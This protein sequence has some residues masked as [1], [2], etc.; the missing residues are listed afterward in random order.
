MGSEAAVGVGRPIVWAL[1]VAV[2]MLV[3]TPST[4]AQSPLQIV[5]DAPETCEAEVFFRGPLPDPLVV[6]WQVSGGEPPYEVLIDGKL[7]EGAT[8][9]VERACGSSIPGARTSGPITIQAAVTDG[10]GRRASALADIYALRVF[11]RSA[12]QENVM[13]ANETYRVHQLLLTIPPGEEGREVRVGGLVSGDCERWGPEC[14]D[15][16]PIWYGTPSGAPLPSIWIQR[17]TGAEYGRSLDGEPVVRE[18]IDEE[19][20]TYEQRE[21]NSYFDELLSLIGQPP[22]RYQVTQPRSGPDDPNLRLTMYA[23]SYCL[24]AGGSFYQG[25]VDVSWEVEGGRGP[26]EVTIAGQRYLGQSGRARVSCYPRKGYQVG[27]HQ[28]VQG[29]VVDADGRISSGRADMY[30]IGW[31]HSREDGTSAGLPYRIREHVMIIPPEWGDTVSLAEERESTNHCWID[32]GGVSRCENALRHTFT[33]GNAT[34]SFLFGVISGTVFERTPRDETSAV[35]NDMIDRLLGSLGAAATA[36]G[37]LPRIERAAA[38]QRLLRA[39]GLR[40]RKLRRQ[41]APALDG[42]RR[43]MVAVDSDH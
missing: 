18:E 17:W 11:D 33:D 41:C 31:V 30:A 9:A 12:I 7:H 28:R 20:L 23:P 35:L 43:S 19:A 4:E 8:G 15:R 5:L 38:A 32:D 42:K 34:A 16:F 39:C 22:R 13:P 27:G 37:R 25:A 29:T 10:A 1:V 36:T 2:A 6:R 21:A 3:G 40:V 26:F 14:D 24:M